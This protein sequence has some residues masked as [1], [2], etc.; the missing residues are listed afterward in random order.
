MNPL[1]VL[2][3][4]VAACWHAWTDLVARVDDATTAAPLLLV[5]AALAAPLATRAPLRPVGTTVPTLLLIAGALATC[6][7]PP[8]FAI[9]PAVLAVAWCL[10][11]AT[12]A[13]SPPAA[14]F[15]LVML[16]LPI[17]PT[18]EFYAAYPVRLAAIEISAALLR[19]QGVAVSVEGLALRFGGEL[20]QFDAPCSGVKM[21]WTCLFLASA[22]AWL[23]RFDWRRYS[24]A[25]G[26]ALVFAI[27]GNIVRA[28][29]LFYV[30][31]GLVAAKGPA[32]LHGTVGVVA[33]A[34]T[35]LSLLAVLK[36]RA[37][38]PA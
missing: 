9:A 18:L 24:L 31:A 27:A 30:E 26:C 15:G 25:L 4:V 19:V 17:L 36:P 28:T 12:R 38:V 1:L 21:L 3:G 16:A 14:F 2:L 29:S 11:A 37:P 33:F 6:I 5:F 22:L 35:A 8:I 10:H 23:Y 20:V 13:G 7:G 34:F 32:W